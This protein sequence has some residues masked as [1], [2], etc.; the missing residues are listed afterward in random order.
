[1]AQNDSTPAEKPSNE[2]L[3]QEITEVL[4]LMP[5]WGTMEATQEI[6][7]WMGRASGAMHL[8]DRTRSTV[9]FTQHMTDMRSSTSHTHY[10]GWMAAAAMLHQAKAELQM[11]SRGP[12]A[13]AFNSGDVF[14]FFD[15]VRK[16]IE[17]AKQDLFFVDRYLDADFV[18]RYL[19]HVSKGTTVRLLARDKIPVLL[20]AVELMATQHGMNIQVRSSQKFHDR[21]LFVDKVE[22]Y[23]SGASF[24][25]GARSSPTTFTQLLDAFDGVFSTYDQFWSEG[26]VHR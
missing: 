11:A 23:Q 21:F 22:A 24:K 9:W 25:D 14:D 10:Q 20:P 8:W 16:Q 1:M 6:M 2:A 5:P 7:A 17:T 3:L 12:A 4:R 13:L 19:P 15:E 18:S 26:I